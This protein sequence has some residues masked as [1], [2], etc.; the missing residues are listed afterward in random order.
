MLHL[1][2][3]LPPPS[4]LLREQ[5]PR[6]MGF[7]RPSGLNVVSTLWAFASVFSLPFGRLP[8]PLA[9]PFVSPQSRRE[10][11]V[12]L[13]FFDFWLLGES[14]SLSEPSRVELFDSFTFAPARRVRLFVFSFFFASGA[15]VVRF[16]G[17]D[18]F[19]RD[20]KRRLLLRLFAARWLI[21][22]REEA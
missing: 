15:R 3:P 12:L 7:S 9:L 21:I 13:L 6:P 5:Q 16:L 2:L 1:T 8:Y 22:R 19:D 18:S 10:M 11:V 14:R 4:L 17:P 20:Y